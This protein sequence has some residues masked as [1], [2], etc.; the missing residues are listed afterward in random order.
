[1]PAPIIRT[2][3]KVG[4]VDLSLLAADREDGYDY[5]SFRTIHGLWYTFTALKSTSIERQ[6]EGKR[7]QPVQ[8]CAKTEVLYSDCFIDLGSAPVFAGQ[9]LTNWLTE[10]RHFPKNGEVS[11]Q[12]DMIIEGDRLAINGQ[13]TSPVDSGWV[14]ERL[15][16]PILANF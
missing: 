5:V 3:G 2:D 6:S 11:L 15:G 4:P 10:R 7:V 1:M 8:L 14:R 9:A 13:E 16:K 12:A